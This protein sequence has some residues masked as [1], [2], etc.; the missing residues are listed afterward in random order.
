MDALFILHA[1]HEQN[2]S[3][4]TVRSVGSTGAT[5]F[6]SLLAGLSALSG[7][8]HGGANVACIHMLEEIGQQDNIA[9][10]LDKAKDK[11]DPFRLMGFGHRVYKNFDP[12]ARVMQ[13]L[14][15]AVLKETKADPLFDLALELEAQALND[16]Y[17]KDRALYPN[18]DYYSGITQKALGIPVSCFT[19]VFALARTAGWMAHWCEML[20]DPD[21]CIYRPRQ[22]YIGQKKREF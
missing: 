8:A 16:D 9:L 19:T 1:E 11:N 3:T 6:S 5:P 7:P 17:F 2:A 4:S 18:V 22:L 12:R 13:G 15:L 21:T 10:F 20:D 14:C